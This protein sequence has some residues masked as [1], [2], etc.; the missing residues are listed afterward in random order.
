MLSATYDLSISAVRADALFASA[1]QR[2]DEPSAGQ[3]RQAIAAAIRVFGCLGCAAR[4][5]QAYGE[6]PETAVTRMCW[7]RMSVAGAFGGS[8]AGPGTC[9]QAQPV[10]T[11]RAARATD[12][13]APTCHKRHLDM[14]SLTVY[15][16]YM[17]GDRNLQLHPESHLPY[18]AQVKHML[19]AQIRNSPPHMQ[20]PSEQALQQQFGVSRPVVRQA[21]G[22]L[23]RDGLIYRRR[24]KG[25][26]V[27]PPKVMEGQ[28]QRLASLN[29]ELLSQGYE[30]VTVVMQQE[31]TEADPLA[32]EQL[33]V[34]PGSPLIFL[35]RL[36][37]V[38]GEPLM[39]ASTLLPY[40]LCP[41]LETMDLA[42][43]VPLPGAGR[44]VRA[45]DHSGHPDP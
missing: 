34:P 35:R 11:S 36:R 6:H 16:A 2:S 41:G 21:L 38:D 8:E 39:V 45:E 17:L 22:E 30:P 1:L 42:T 25:S 31:L 13:S 3:V 9:P 15:G 18:Y 7:A 20:L 23:V 26:F 37:L 29:E 44:R 19:Q 27:A 14:M 43:E 33:E 32:G 5:A 10:C 12:R 24:G 4:V 40:D 28:V